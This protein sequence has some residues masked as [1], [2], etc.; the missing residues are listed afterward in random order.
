MPALPTRSA[1]TR[2][3]ERMKHVL[4]EFVGTPAA[5]Y[6]TSA[7]KTMFDQQ[8]ITGFRDDFLSLSTEDITQIPT[9]TVPEK[10]KLVCVL[11]LANSRLKLSNALVLSVL[12]LLIIKE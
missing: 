4:V 9:I 12:L 11:K 1:A 7:I 8:G 3:A 5:T 6:D 10:R 2:D